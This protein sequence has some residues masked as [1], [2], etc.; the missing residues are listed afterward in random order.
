MRKAYRRALESAKLA[1]GK[2]FVAQVRRDASSDDVARECIAIAEEAFGVEFAR[3]WSNG[4]DEFPLEDDEFA[5]FYESPMKVQR[6]AEQRL[7]GKLTLDDGPR[8]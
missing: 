7:L 4:N 6:I 1:F 8:A 5:S 2:P 3:A